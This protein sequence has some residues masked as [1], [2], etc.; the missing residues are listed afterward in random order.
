[1]SLIDKVGLMPNISTHVR[2]SNDFVIISETE[3]II[4][5]PSDVDLMPNI[6]MQIPIPLI[7]ENMACGYIFSPNPNMISR[8]ISVIDTSHLEETR[9]IYIVIKNNT[10]IRKIIPQGFKM[11]S[12]ILTN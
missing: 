4:N 12:I 2:Y 9:I 3:I 7:I 11:G 5:T 1:M 6:S 8:D 10:D